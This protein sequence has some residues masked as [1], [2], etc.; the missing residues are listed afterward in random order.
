MK[1]ILQAVK[2]L[3]RK[4]D[5]TRDAIFKRVDTDISAMRDDVDSRLTNVMSA[6]DPV[7]TGSFSMGR[8]EGSPVG[9][10]SYAAGY[11]V[12]ASGLGSH[13]E[14]GFTTASGIYSHAE[15][16]T[17]SASAFYS[18]AEGDSTEASGTCSHAEGYRT[19]AASYGS[20]VEGTYNIADYDAKYLHIAGNG[21]DVIGS[22]RSNAHTLDWEGNAWYQGDVYV[23]S[24]S[25]VN[26]DEGSKKL[27]TEEY[28]NN[29]ILTGGN[30]GGG[31]IVT[32]WNDLSD[33]PFGEE[34]NQTVIEWDGN[35][36]GR[37]QLT[38]DGNLV[39]YYKVSDLIPTDKELG[40]CVL[41]YSDGHI[42]TAKDYHTEIG[43]NVALIGNGSVAVLYDT[44]A[45][46][47]GILSA[48][49]TGVYFSMFDTYATKLT[50]YTTTVKTIDPKFLPNDHIESLINS[51]LA[52]FGLAENTSF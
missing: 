44:N 12:V 9:D 51:K 28:V 41:V 4:M 32:S 26:R 43:E 38:V 35:T 17:A 39:P 3:A 15:G 10:K 29:A 18:H 13:A 21:Y 52:E 7:A 2:A 48:P 16:A 37:D 27:A 14:G 36:E 25:G 8:K 40:D 5:S 6:S 1:L 33:R 31:S 24:N 50:Y 34:N 45:Q 49:S 11:D 42:L 46:L 20:H 30:P 19:I 23:G 22:T 47:D